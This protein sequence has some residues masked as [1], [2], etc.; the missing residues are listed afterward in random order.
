MAAQA[1]FTP[2]IVEHRRCS[3]DDDVDV[4]VVSSLSA[5]EGA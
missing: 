5:G 1:D 3:H 4:V 2:L